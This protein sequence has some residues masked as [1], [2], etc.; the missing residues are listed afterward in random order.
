MNAYTQFGDTVVG[1]DERFDTMGVR[2]GF[3]GR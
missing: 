1:F 3:I 2:V